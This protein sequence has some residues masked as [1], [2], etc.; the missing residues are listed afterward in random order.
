MILDWI[1]LWQLR[2][3]NK[4]IYR[5]TSAYFTLTYTTNIQQIPASLGHAKHFC[6][7]QLTV[8]LSMKTSKKKKHLKK[9]KDYYFYSWKAPNQ[10][11][12]SHSLFNLVFS[13]F[14]WPASWSHCLTN[15]KVSKTPLKPAT[16]W[17]TGLWCF[18]KPGM[19]EGSFDRVDKWKDPC[20][21]NC[22]QAT[23]LLYTYQK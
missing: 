19:T 9:H 8:L 20:L 15:W 7:R 2:Q 21:L 13:W 11:M 10:L 6:S 1:K 18:F 17:K 5:K 4:N 14:S 23:I 16:K 22:Q 3:S 12:W